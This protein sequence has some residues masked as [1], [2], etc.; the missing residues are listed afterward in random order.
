MR[1]VLIDGEGM[2]VKSEITF[3]RTSINSVRIIFVDK[4]GTQHNLDLDMVQSIE[5]N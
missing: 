1:V 2:V 5:E 3:T 4:R